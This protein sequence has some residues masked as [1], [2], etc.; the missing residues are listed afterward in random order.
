[1]KT[2]I[3]L[4]VSVVIAL[5]CWSGSVHAMTKTD[6][7]TLKMSAPSDWVAG[8][9]QQCSWDWGNLDGN[10]EVTLWKS[11]QLVTT[12]APSCAI[13]TNGTGSMTV[14]VPEKLAAGA[15]EVRVKSLKHPE[16]VAKQPVNLV[17]KP[18]K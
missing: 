17:A 3:R 4:V 14:A 7:A 12:L 18:R 6:K 8:T 13:G 2:Y 15:Y 1:M 10:V 16:V 9:S 11:N 5:A